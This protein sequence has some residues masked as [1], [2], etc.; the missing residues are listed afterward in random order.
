MAFEDLHDDSDLEIGVHYTEDDWLARLNGDWI[1]P[2]G[3]K[4]AEVEICPPKPR[5][6]VN[7]GAE[8]EAYKRCA[9]MCERCGVKGYAFQ[10]NVHHLHYRTVGNECQWDLLIVCRQCHRKEHSGMFLDWYTDT[11]QAA[12]VLWQFKQ[13]CLKAD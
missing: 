3:D 12:A 8:R 10:F 5:R 1:P 7:K 11:E 13:D 9:G 6:A 2:S 4:R